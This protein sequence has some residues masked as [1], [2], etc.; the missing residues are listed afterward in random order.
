MLIVCMLR[1]KLSYIR[2]ECECRK[3]MYLLYKHYY[4]RYC[5][6]TEDYIDSLIEQQRNIPIPTGNRPGQHKL[7]EEIFIIVVHLIFSF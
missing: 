4:M 6:Y 7:L 2:P 5:L 3:L 1:I